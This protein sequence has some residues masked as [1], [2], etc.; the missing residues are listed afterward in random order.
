MEFPKEINDII[1]SYVHVPIHPLQICMDSHETL[2]GSSFSMAMY[3]KHWNWFKLKCNDCDK[4]IKWVKFNRLF[5]NAK[6]YNIVNNARVG[7]M[8]YKCSQCT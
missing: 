4:I 1:I 5:N 2:T 7:I 3:T 6:V 8:V